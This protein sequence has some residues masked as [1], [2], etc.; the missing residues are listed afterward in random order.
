VLHPSQRSSGMGARAK[1][2]GKWQPCHSKLLIS[3]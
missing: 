1:T 2:R 3:Q